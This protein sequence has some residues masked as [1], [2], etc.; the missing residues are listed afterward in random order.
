MAKKKAIVGNDD[1]TKC[2]DE[3]IVQELIHRIEAKIDE[4]EN[5]ICSL[6]ADAAELGS[7]L[8]ELR[9]IEGGM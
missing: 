3:R 6:Q 9:E 2:T 5:E 1:L 7:Q 4:V 8:D